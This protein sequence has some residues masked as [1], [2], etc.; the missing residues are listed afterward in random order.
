MDL[1]MFGKLSNTAVE[2]WPI[3]V[4]ALLLIQNDVNFTLVKI[5]NYPIKDIINELFYYFINNINEL[6][7]IISKMN[8]GDII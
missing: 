1:K 4:T 2:T 5:N 3:Y 7:Y 6:F 8:R